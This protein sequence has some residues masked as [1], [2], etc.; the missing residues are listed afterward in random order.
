M[1][2]GRGISTRSPLRTLPFAGGQQ[3][4][5]ILGP[6]IGRSSLGT[7]AGDGAALSSIPGHL[8]LLVGYSLEIVEWLTP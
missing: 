7:M 3:G 8:R 1:P 5:A 2:V 6:A 4:R